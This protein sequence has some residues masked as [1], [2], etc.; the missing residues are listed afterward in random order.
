MSIYLLW[1][2]DDVDLRRHVRTSLNRVEGYHQLIRAITNV[3][4]GEF[5]GKS[6][7]E[8]LIWNECA[9]LVANAVIYYNAYMLSQILISKINNGDKITEKI[10]NLLKRISPIAWQHLI[11]IGS[12]DFSLKNGV[13]IH[14]ILAVIKRYFEEELLKK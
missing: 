13:N 8:I 3:G 10:I 5:R 1:Y 4:G 11:F 7:M 2:I 6:E 14:E 9:R 12:Y